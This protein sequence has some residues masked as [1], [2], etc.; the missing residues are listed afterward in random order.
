MAGSIWDERPVLISLE[1]KGTFMRGQMRALTS[2]SAQIVADDPCLL[3]NAVR[4]DVRFRYEDTI[5]SLSGM[6]ITNECDEI[7]TLQFDLVTRQN[8]A[9]LRS[10]GVTPPEPHHRPVPSPSGPR[11]R[12]KAEQRV[13]LH[14]PPPE[15]IERRVQP[16]YEFETVATL[17]VLDNGSALTT[18]LLE[19][20]LSGCRLFSE[21]PFNLPAESRVEVRFLGQGLPFRLAGEAKLK[22]DEHLL[23]VFFSAMSSRCKERLR[24]LIH[25]LAERKAA[26]K[27]SWKE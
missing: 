25:E 2:T 4:A 8:M 21:T 17:V 26:H 20:S 1:A 5:Y 11:K 7:I 23:G 16:R 24:E 15:G 19:I 14:S 9:M 12:T 27:A 6:A 18:T 3:H 22:R 13:V 10:L